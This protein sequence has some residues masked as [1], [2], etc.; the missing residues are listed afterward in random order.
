[1]HKKYRYFLLPLI[2]I[3]LFLLFRVL[4]HNSTISVLQPKGLIGEKERSLMFFAVLLSVVVVIPVFIMTFAI[5]WRY[6]EGNTKAQYS[7]N[8]DRSRI[9]EAIWWVLPLAL[10]IVLSVVTW[11]S[12]HE[13]DPYH[14]VSSTVKPLTI[15]VV[16]LDW[17]WLFIYPEQNIATVNYVQFPENTPITFKVTADAPMNSFWIP[18]LGGQIYAMPGMIT[19]LHLM[20]NQLG[21]YTGSSANISGEGFAGM[22]FVARATSKADFEAWARAVQHTPN[23]LNQGTYAQFAQ[24]SKN[25][26]QAYYSPVQPDLYDKIL[27]KFMG[28]NGHG[29]QPTM[30]GMGT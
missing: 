17:K 12:S 14:S 8:F 22:H 4:T 2:P 19:Q 3:G 23:T 27:L 20:A 29:T 30:D 9:A 13:L 16:A 24:P 21:S 18:Q 1:M 25:A 6:R 26:L 7:P 5:A 11:R 10:I 28:P 15:Q